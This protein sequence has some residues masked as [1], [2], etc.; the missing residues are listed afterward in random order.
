LRASALRDKA[1]AL[2]HFQVFGDAGEA[3]VKRLGQLRDRGLSKGETSQD[4]PPGG[5]GE[6]CKRDAQLI[7]RRIF[8]VS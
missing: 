4:R 5:I 6:G 2:Q 1:G 7:C 8:L 3:Q